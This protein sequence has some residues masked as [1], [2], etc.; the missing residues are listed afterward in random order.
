MRP[1]LLHVWRDDAY[2]EHPCL[3]QK[4]SGDVAQ[5]KQCQENSPVQALKQALPTA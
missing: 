4:G 3:L 5:S 1:C 2:E